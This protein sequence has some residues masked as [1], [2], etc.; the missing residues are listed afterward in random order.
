VLKDFRD[1]AARAQL[2]RHPAEREPRP[3]RDGRQQGAVLRGEGHGSPGPVPARSR[4]RAELHS[5]QYSGSEQSLRQVPVHERQ[6]RQSEPRSVSGLAVRPE[7]RVVLRRS[8]TGRSDAVL[9]GVDSFVVVETQSIFVL[10]EAG[11]RA[12]PVSVPV[13]GQAATSRV[14]SCQGSTPSTGVSALPRTTPTR[15]PNRDSTT[16]STRRCRSRAC[17]RTPSTPRSTIRTKGFEARL[18][19][20]WRDKSFDSNFGFPMRSALRPQR[21]HHAHVGR[22]ES[23]TMASWMRRSPINS[24]TSSG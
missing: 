14:S 18:S 5:R 9:E 1:A 8:R 23:R 24:A 20:G 12:G 11:G 4:L 16:T 19:Y 10:D 7:L 15:T 17:R 13:N 2:H 22:M 3:G 6:H 21:R